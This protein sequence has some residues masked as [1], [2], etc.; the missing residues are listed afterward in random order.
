MSESGEHPPYVRLGRKA[1]GFTLV[2][3][4]IVVA[5]VGILASLA[6][7]GVRKYTAIAKSAE[8]VNSIGCIAMAVRMAADRDRTSTDTLALG[9]SSTLAG[10][11]TTTGSTSGNGNGNGK[12]A[13]VTHGVST[14]LC[15]SSDPVPASL[16]SIKGKKY[17]PTPS[18]Y[19]S[20]DSTTGWRCLL[21]SSEMPQYYQYRYRAGG[22]GGVSVTLP[23]GGN[24]KGLSQDYEWFVTAQGDLDGDGE[25]STF[26]LEGYIDTDG[27]VVTAPAIGSDHSDE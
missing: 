6:N 3:L 18:D 25:L 26:G 10:N 23:H 1:R 15:D 14:G 20:G 17:Q 4:M 22:S 21:F 27:R 19:R 13:T 16:N 7:Y 9:T 11:G 8:A 24:P 2:E 5:I 12:G